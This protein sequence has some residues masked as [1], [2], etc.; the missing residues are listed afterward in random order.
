MVDNLLCDVQANKDA[1][2]RYGA[3]LAALKDAEWFNPPRMAVAE[4]PSGRILVSTCVGNM[5]GLSMLGGSSLFEIVDNTIVVPKKFGMRTVVNAFASQ[6][7]CKL[8]EYVPIDEA[9]KPGESDFEYV[10]RIAKTILSRYEECMGELDRNAAEY[11]KKTGDLVDYLRFALFDVMQAIAD[12]SPKLSM[13]IARMTEVFYLLKEHDPVT[14][15]MCDI[16]DVYTMAALADAYSYGCTRVFNRELGM[17]HVTLEPGFE[18]NLGVPGTNRL[19]YYKDSRG[20]NG[21]FWLLV[22]RHDNPPSITVST[23]PKPEH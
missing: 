18:K 21:E 5:S 2:G 6:V 11:R 15:S 23:V 12:R 1:I 14:A 3:L 9:K 20:G 8:D 19:V 7:E 10:D 16:M 17:L 4:I 13:H 22:E